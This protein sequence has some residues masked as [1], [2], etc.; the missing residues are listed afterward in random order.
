MP[1]DSSN[2]TLS[3]KYSLFLNKILRYLFFKI[4]K[5]D[6]FSKKCICLRNFDSVSKD[7]RLGMYVYVMGAY[8]I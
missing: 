6:T 4:G 7:H 3:L 5:Y 2:N 8:T 1:E